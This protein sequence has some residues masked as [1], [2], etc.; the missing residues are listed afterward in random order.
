MLQACVHTHPFA[1]GNHRHENASTC[2]C[3]C[4]NVCVLVCVCACVRVCVCARVRADVC[5]CVCARVCHLRRRNTP[6]EN[7]SHSF[8]QRVRG[9]KTP[10]CFHILCVSRLL[11]LN[12]V[13]DTFVCCVRM[14]VR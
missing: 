10:E 14:C 2:V 9:L 8:R 12:A 4:V 1:Y 5:A 11:D 13:C 7:A 6:V 3:V